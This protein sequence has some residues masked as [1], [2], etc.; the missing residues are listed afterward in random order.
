MSIYNAR[1]D[2]NIRALDG[3]IDIF[4]IFGDIEPSLAA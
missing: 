1:Y 3:F 4:C 2:Q